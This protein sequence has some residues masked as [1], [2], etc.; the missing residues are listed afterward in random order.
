M[1]SNRGNIGNHGL[2][3]MHANEIRNARQGGSRG[4]LRGGLGGS[5]SGSRGGSRGGS[6]SGSQSASQ[7]GEISQSNTPRSEVSIDS[8]AQKLKESINTREELFKFLEKGSETTS[9]DDMIEQLYT[10]MTLHGVRIRHDQFDCGMSVADAAEVN[11]VAKAA[12]AAS[13]TGVAKSTDATNNTEATGVNGAAEATNNIGAA[14]ANGANGAAE[15]N[16]ATGANGAVDATNIIGATS[17]AAMADDVSEVS[18]ATDASAL[19]SVTTTNS[20]ASNKSRAR[21]KHG[22]SVPAPI[23]RGRNGMHLLTLSRLFAE[24]EPIQPAP[25]RGSTVCRILLSGSRGRSSRSIQR[26]FGGLLIDART[27]RIIAAPPPAFNLRPAANA[28]DTLLAADAYDIIRVDDG[29]V[30]TIYCWN[31]PKN[32]PTWAMATSNGYDVSALYWMGSLTYAEVFIDL[33]TRLYPEFTA[34]TGAALDKSTGETRLSFKNLDPAFSYTIGFRHHNFHPMI[35]DPERMW[36]IQAVK[37]SES[38]LPVV[39]PMSLPG[40]PVQEVYSHETLAMQMGVPT[41]TLAHIRAVGAT[42]FETAVAHIGGVAVASP[43]YLAL[44][45]GYILRL[46]PTEILSPQAIAAVAAFPDHAHV[47]VET[48]LL[49]R[50]RRLIYERAPRAVRDSITSIERHSYNAMR[51]YLMPE[52]QRD[53]LRLFP[54]WTQ[55][56]NEFGKFV[57]NVIKEAVHTLRQRAHTPPSRDP[58]PTTM[59]GH[60][61]LAL[62][63]HICK[64]T[65]LAAP[66]RDAESIVRDLISVPE[67]AYLFLR[68][69]GVKM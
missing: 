29:T 51:A 31:H 52:E 18:E 45:Y 47:L 4:G 63:D 9:T 13:A 58:R 61:A 43:A 57:G 48:P 2:R 8:T 32:G 16:G 21:S 55:R 37:S 12:D 68:A 33:V 11:G 28:V 62:V 41:L 60:I 50:V 67:N 42:S 20:M 69:S 17:E 30:V 27:W 39:V 56:F 1:H 35:S 44:N 5:R 34:I 49:T 54:S 53:Y 65:K 14:E 23:E 66:H 40:I 24:D 15:A 46:R 38:M 36:L 22:V 7:S 64:H 19:D 6:Q 26:E 3:Y 10:I 25:V 59:A